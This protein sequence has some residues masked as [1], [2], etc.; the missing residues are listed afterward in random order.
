MKKILTLH[1]LSVLVSIG[2]GSQFQTLELSS[3]STDVS[4]SLTCTDARSKIFDA[5]YRAYQQKNSF[6]YMQKEIQTLEERVPSLQNAPLHIRTQFKEKILEI[7]SI[8]TSE[9][10]KLKNRPV[11]TLATLSGTSAVES[12]LD[13]LLHLARIEMRS[14]IEPAY[15]M[16][17]NKL[18]SALKQSAKLAQIADLPCD[19]GAPGSKVPV[20]DPKSPLANPENPS[21]PDTPIFSAKHPLYGAYFVMATSYQSCQ[22]LD[23]PPVTNATE[24]ARGVER[25][26]AIDSYGYGRVYT[27]IEALVKSHY[28][29]QGQ[30]YGPECID[31][32]K[33]PLVYDYGGKPTFQE[34][35]LNMFVDSGGGSALGIDCSAFISTAA[36]VAGNRYNPSSENKTVYTRFVSR[37]FID[38]TKSNWTCYESVNVAKDASIKPGD[39][40]AVEGHVVMVDKVGIDPFGISRVKKAAA[41][42][43]LTTKNFDFVVIQSSPD[44]GNL[45]I[46]R[47]EAKD[48]LMGT[49]KMSDLF[50]DY[51]RNACLSQIDGKARSL[52]AIKHRIIRHKQTANCLAPR[53]VLAN[54][55]CVRTCSAFGH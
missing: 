8:M 18:D 49:G 55:T 25:G 33:K 40:A 46:N 17:N 35:S 37:D 45:G 7:H 41:C 32:R 50:L 30:T 44:K 13:P 52:K 5:Y 47:F 20:E 36:A 34:Q 31:Q 14:K 21:V 1:L 3:L 43:N 16:L 53:A 39:I 12:E 4:D 2:C 48:Y 38:P 11:G 10:E 27:D 29:H 28:Y 51:A 24:P 15:E 19:I 26:S 9:I 22:V 42:E 23:L 54:E 6:L